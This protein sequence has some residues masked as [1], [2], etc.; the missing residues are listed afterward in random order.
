MN[1]RVR[2]AGGRYPA[3]II[4][5][6]AVTVGFAL[7][8]LLP[9]EQLMEREGAAIADG[10]WWRILSSV[11]VQG[12]GWGQ[13]LFNTVGLVVVGAAV[14]KTRG[15]IQWVA[16]VVVAQV[17]ASLAALAWTPGVPDSGSSLFVSGLV[18]MLSVTWFVKPV[19]W[20]ALAAGYQVFFVWYLAV[21]ALFGPLA[22]AVVG[23]VLTGVAVS[24][25][26]RSGFAVWALTTTLV[27]TVLAF[28]LLIAARDQHGI[29]VLLGLVVALTASFAS[30]YRHGEW[31][32]L[33]GRAGR[34]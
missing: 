14:E 33:D 12:S 24:V 29:A 22:G 11:L 15:S 7:Q 27:L 16:G 13:Y 25:L 9:L 26:V 32:R 34:R 30:S 31:R 3:T 4:V 2:S 8:W 1:G 21:L 20:A 28:V 19:Q 23:S 18:G 10:Q 6:V 17:G 5:S